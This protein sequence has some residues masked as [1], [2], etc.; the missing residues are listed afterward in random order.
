MPTPRWRLI[1]PHY[2]HVIVDGERSQWEYSEQSRETGRMIRRRF[3][4]PMFLDPKDQADHNYKELG[5][6]IVCQGEPD[7]GFERDFKFF[8]EPGPDMEPMNEEAQAITDKLKAKWEHPIEGLSATYGD[9]VLQSFEQQLKDV[10]AKAFTPVAQQ[11]AAVSTDVLVQ[12]KAMQDQINALTNQNAALVADKEGV[13]VVKDDFEPLPDLALEPVEPSPVA[14]PV[15][16]LKRQPPINRP[17]QV[18]S[19]SR[20]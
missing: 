15:A 9:V 3:E 16:P 10:M 7:R 17:P 19:A 14:L 4:V 11:P 6:I 13:E 20:R 8:G 5:L 1:G 2:I 12:L 18:A